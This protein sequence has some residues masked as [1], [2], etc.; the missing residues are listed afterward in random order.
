MVRQRQASR[1]QQGTPRAYLPKKNVG[2]GLR[3][4]V[5]IGFGF[6]G[7]YLFVTL[8]TYNPLD[9]GL[10]HSGQVTE[11]KNAGGVAGAYFADTLFYLFGYFAY[12]FPVMI[13]YL[14]WI[15]YQGQHHH[16]L[17]EPR[18]WGIPIIGFA[19]TLSAG[20]G[21][22]IV[23]FATANVLLPSHAGGIL[24]MAVGKTLESIF[25][26]LGA[27][28]ILLVLFFT[29]ITLSTGL[30]WLRVMD[31]LGYHTLRYLPI[32]HI[33]LS[34]QIFPR[35]SAVLS[36]SYTITKQVLYAVFLRTRETYDNVKLAWRERIAEWRHEHQDYEEDE[37]YDEY[38]DEEEKLDDKPEKPT[39]RGFFGRRTT[40]SEA[41]LVIEEDELA[42]SATQYKA[43]ETEA[44][45]PTLSVKPFVLPP[46]KLL[47]DPPLPEQEF[48]EEEL[49]R[50]VVRLCRRLN[51][52]VEV[53]AVY[54]GPVLNGVELKAL[55]DLPFPYLEDFNEALARAMRV[56]KVQTVETQPGLLSLEIANPHR[57]SI[58]LRHLLQTPEYADNHSRLCV[59]LG[60]D[61]RGMPIIVD[62]N[63]IP[64]ILMAGSD[65]DDKQMALHA[66]LLSL[67]YKST[68]QELR[69]ALIASPQSDFTPYVDIPHLL[70]PISSEIETTLTIL[71]WC[72]QEMER[73]YHAM[74]E[75]GVRNIEGYNE[76]VRNDEKLEFLEEVAAKHQTIPYLVIVIEE[77][78]ELMHHADA[79]KAEDLISE[80]AQ[81][82]R[83]AGIHLLLATQYPT[84]NVVT[85]LLKNQITTRI[86]FRVEN[87]TES[88]TI[89]GQ[90][91]AENLLGQ[92]D[93]LYMT[94]GTGSAVRVHG[95]EVSTEEV[96]DVVQYLKL[97]ASPDYISL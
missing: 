47:E 83:A 88:R 44:Y 54:P 20:C 21:L 3:E 10:S 57:H 71:Q 24:G 6:L 9:P 33:F 28:L 7:L 81:K 39:K 84:V 12:L 49:S 63:R 18:K 93:M 56:A 42:Q 23:H 64:H 73:R 67:L 76:L 2:H 72:V 87:R 17:T 30:S 29:G 79:Q 43:S 68:P 61:L 8:V 45:Q 95:C 4:L 77:I 34:E 15:I 91:G 85:G 48:D 65:P 59:A 19:I 80:I 32:L 94:A 36:N 74:T 40:A 13:A 41:E 89:L 38:F 82:S 90:M 75:L 1:K 86:A 92:G 96:Q 69:L 22:A 46:L 66:T 5:L 55:S 26:Q 97:Q 53:K 31:N 51:F 78:A 70:T 50:R 58:M 25:D 16:I 62:L 37:Y 27:T 35:I 11:V 52:D 14:G 60:R